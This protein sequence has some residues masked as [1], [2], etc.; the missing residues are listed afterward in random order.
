MS[1]LIFVKIGDVFKVASGGT[2]GR[3]KPEYY[4][5][6]NIPWVKTGDLKGKYANYPTE[7]IT[8]EALKNSSAKIFPKNTILLAMYGA[9]IGACSILP[10][11]AATNQ[12]CGALLPTDKY[13]TDFLFYYLKSIKNDLI[14]KGVGG[15]QPNIS[16]GIIKET[17]IPVLEL[18]LQRKIANILDAADALRQNDKALI[19]K[20]DEL[21]QAL[22]LDM[23]GDPVSN[24]K[25]WEM[26][27]LKDFINKLNT[28][29]SVNSEDVSYENG[30][31]FILKTSCVYSGIFDPKQVKTIREDEIQRAK[32]NPKKD[33]IIISR[34]NTP[35][36]VGKSAYIFNDFPNIYL[37]DR[38]WQ[39][40]KTDLAHSVLWLSYNVGHKSFMNEISKISSGTSGSMKNIS[41]S[42]FLELKSINPP[43][44][45]QNQFAERVTQIEKQK[46][47]AQKS[48]EKSESLFNSLLQ[49]AFK[50]E[51]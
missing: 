49:K 44:D 17:L 37:P 50:G 10:F 1:N 21:T 15:A 26:V 16:S 36:L 38:L 34:M 42:A 30:H 43:I 18:K 46:A 13:D 35:E 31:V 27:K 6:G 22:F 14:K 28:G 23:F 45:L 24:P 48:L 12:A 32:L 25:G 11:D 41:K 2:P 9:T 8:D 7:H 40:E 4:L 5:G 47:I 20:Y 29:V 3:D 19:A 51:L 33:S 39:T